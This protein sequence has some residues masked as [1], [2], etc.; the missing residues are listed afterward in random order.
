[1]HYP[2]GMPRVSGAFSR[3]A[4]RSLDPIDPAA[5]ARTL[6]PAT[7]WPGPLAEVGRRSWRLLAAT[8][9]F[10]AWVIAWPQGGHVSLHD[11]GPSRGALAVVQGTLAETVPW[12]DDAGRLTLVRHDL[13]VGSLLSLEMGH[14]HDVTNSRPETAVSLHVYSPP[15]T[16]MTYYD[17]TGGRTLQARSMRKARQWK[18]GVGSGG[19]R[20]DVCLAG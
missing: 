20:R 1:M 19:D 4:R 7:R 5:I 2:L 16:S 12:R 14:I 18:T 8:P 9:Q 11:H 15:L 3:S 13:P 6:A 17:M 10:D